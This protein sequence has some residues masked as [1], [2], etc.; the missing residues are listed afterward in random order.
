MGGEGGGRGEQE[1]QSVSR[2]QKKARAG[3]QIQQLPF[4]PTLGC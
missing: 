4:L 3:A 1:N 2:A